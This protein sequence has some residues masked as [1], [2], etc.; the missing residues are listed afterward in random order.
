[1]TSLPRPPAVLAAAAAADPTAPR[2]T[3]YDDTDGPTRGERVELSGRVLSTWVAKAA[4]ALQEEHGIGPGST[5]A[6]VLPAHWRALV[7]MLATWSAGGTLVLGDPTP[8]ADVVV[9]DDPALLETVAGEGVLVTLAALARSAPGPVPSGVM[10]EARDLATYADRFEPWARAADED[11]ALVA[12]GQET[13]YGSL[14]AR[15]AP[16]EPLDEGSRAH[17]ATAD[18]LE[19]ASLALAAWAG[20]GSLV[21][22]RGAAPDAPQLP[23]RLASERVTASR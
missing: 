20:G 10:D 19:L 14:T 15:L 17:T 7:W 12:A 8:S 21:H 22:S 1:M 3:S 4:N 16:A 18:P 5:V 23:A 13:A 6:L 9:S 2:L 11:V